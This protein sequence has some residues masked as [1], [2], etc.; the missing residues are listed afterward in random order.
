MV[1]GVDTSEIRQ[2]RSIVTLIVFVLASSR[3]SCELFPRA[4]IMLFLMITRDV[5]NILSRSLFQ[6]ISSLRL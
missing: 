3:S 5:R 4:R 2:W 1:K 6:S